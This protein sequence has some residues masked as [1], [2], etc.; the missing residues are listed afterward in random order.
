MLSMSWYFRSTYLY[1]VVHELVLPGEEEVVVVRLV[2][3]LKVLQL[4]LLHRAPRRVRPVLVLERPWEQQL[5]I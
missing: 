5:G 2:P 1:T 4:V 3:A